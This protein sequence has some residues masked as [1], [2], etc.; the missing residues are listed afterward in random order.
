[1]FGVPETFFIDHDGIIVGKISGESNALL[2]G[3]TIDQILK[4]VRPGDHTAGTVQSEPG[5]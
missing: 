2:L 5:D 3:S 4:G 1:M